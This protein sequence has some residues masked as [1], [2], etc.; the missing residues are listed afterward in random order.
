MGDLKSS[1]LSG[2]GCATHK[3][4]QS[5]PLKWMRP[6]TWASPQIRICRN[7]HKPP[8]LV[9][10]QNLSCMCSP[11]GLVFFQLIWHRNKCVPNICTVRAGAVLSVTPSRKL[12]IS[13]ACSQNRGCPGSCW[14]RG[15]ISAQPEE[16]LWHFPCPPSVAAGAFLLRKWNM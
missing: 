2:A 10:V 14:R 7:E 1:E 4:S 16:K 13:S 8:V 11:K 5:S 6:T 3:L 9:P 15:D 12:P